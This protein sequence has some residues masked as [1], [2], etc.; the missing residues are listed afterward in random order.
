MIAIQDTLISEDIIEKKFICDLERCKGACCVAGDMGAPLEKEELNT[1][2]SIIDEVIPYMSKSGVDAISLQGLAIID[3]ADGEPTT[4]LI[5]D[6]ECAFTVFENDIAYCAFEK[7]YKDK[8]TNFQ[9]PISCHLYPVRISKYE[10]YVAVN[11]HEWE[12][13]DPACK[14]GERLNTPLYKFL[15]EPLIRKF[16]AEWYEMLDQAAQINT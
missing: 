1:I 9:K 12:I 11:Y 14:L 10:N 6:K 13:C 16:G 5:N 3:P 7:A 15:K 2:E 4:P 8:K